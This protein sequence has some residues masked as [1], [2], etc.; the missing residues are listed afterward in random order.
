M[1]VSLTGIVKVTNELSEKLEVDM[2]MIIIDLYITVS[3]LKG[4][5][6]LSK[7]IPL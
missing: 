7:V 6:F 1:I 3:N 4:N 2:D 5:C